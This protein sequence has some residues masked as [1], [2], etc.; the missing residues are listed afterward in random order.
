MRERTFL[1]LLALT[2]Q[3]RDGSGITRAVRELSGGA[4]SLRAATLYGELD[5]LTGCELIE[6]DREEAWRGR[7]RRYYRLDYHGAIELDRQ[8]ALRRRAAAM[9]G[10][11]GAAMG[12]GLG[13]GGGSLW[14]ILLRGLSH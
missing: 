11:A 9:G 12:G 8:S 1:I 6:V 14:R 5:R 4:V 2:P 13:A 3:A 10:G 7:M